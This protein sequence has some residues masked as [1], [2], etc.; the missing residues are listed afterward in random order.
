MNYLTCTS[1]RLIKDKVFKDNGYHCV[2]LEKAMNRQK[3][4]K[5]SF[6]KKNK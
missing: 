4:Q 6:I 2:N 1:C 5:S 3:I